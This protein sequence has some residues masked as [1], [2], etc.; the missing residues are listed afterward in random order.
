MVVMA[1]GLQCVVWF[2]GRC[3]E[4]A[5][6]PVPHLLHPHIPCGHGEHP[7]QTGEPGI[8]R[9]LGPFWLLVKIQ[10]GLCVSG[11]CLYSHFRNR[12]LNVLS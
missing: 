5:V 7:A 11:I 9:S 3:R 1:T 6:L 10:H 2:V 8:Q 12:K 4:G